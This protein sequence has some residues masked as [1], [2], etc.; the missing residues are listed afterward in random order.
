M[1][2]NGILKVQIVFIKLGGTW[3]NAKIVVGPQWYGFY[4]INHG[5]LRIQGK[6]RPGTKKLQTTLQVDDSRIE[7]NSKEAP[8][9]LAG[10]EWR[11]P[12]HHLPDVW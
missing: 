8:K 11:A 12:S 2:F 10:V 1:L 6:Y 7:C 3:Y 9:M 5:I 4:P